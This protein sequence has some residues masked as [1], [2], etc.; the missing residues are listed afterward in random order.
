[1]IIPLDMC[2]TQESFSKEFEFFSF[3][4]DSSLHEK[5]LKACFALNKKKKKPL[6]ISSQYVVG[7]NVLEKV[8]PY[9]ICNTE[10]HTK[11]DHGHQV[12]SGLDL[13]SFYLLKKQGSYFAV[14]CSRLLTTLSKSPTSPVLSRIKQNLVLAKKA[15]VPVLFISGSKKIS[16]SKR[17]IVKHLF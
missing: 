5:E 12:N 1:M 10:Y 3:S 17:E 13:P 16:S 11:G 4:R 6:V 7:R 8:V 15:K 9:L 2:F 14:D